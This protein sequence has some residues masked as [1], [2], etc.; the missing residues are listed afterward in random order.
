MSVPAHRL[1]CCG[2]IAF[3]QRQSFRVARVKQV[4]GGWLRPK[5]SPDNSAA[6]M[7]TFRI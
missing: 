2:K 3:W 4:M 1:K 6:F 5:K 7:G